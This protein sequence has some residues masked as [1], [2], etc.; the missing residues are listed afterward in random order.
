MAAD[1]GGCAGGCLA[2]VALVVGIFI[3]AFEGC[4]AL[5]ENTTSDTCEERYEE[6]WG[7]ALACV[8]RNG[9]RQCR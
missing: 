3:A 1:A 8:E 9:L 7:A 2:A 5:V 6:G 4:G